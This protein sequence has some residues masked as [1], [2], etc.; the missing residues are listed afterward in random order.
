MAYQEIVK[1][2]KCGA[3]IRYIRM[4]R[5]G[6]WMPVN[7]KPVEVIP[8]IGMDKGGHTFVTLDG[9]AFRARKKREDVLF[10]DGV[11]IIGAFESHF[12]TCPAADEYRRKKK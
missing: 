6:K 9:E 4:K 5:S 11:D 8:C 12:A 1:C 2:G 10:Y 3:P 7:A